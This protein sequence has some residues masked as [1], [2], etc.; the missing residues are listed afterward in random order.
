VMIE[1]KC[2]VCWKP[3]VY[4][5]QDLDKPQTLRCKATADVFVLPAKPP[6]GRL[7]LF[8]SSFDYCRD[9]MWRLITFPAKYTQ[10]E[11][12]MLL[13]A[14]FGI[15]LAYVLFPALLLCLLLLS[16]LVFLVLRI[17][18]G[19]GLLWRGI[20][21]RCPYDD[22]GR[23][24]LPIHICSCGNQYADL[25][26]DF[27]H[28]L[29]FHTCQHD[30]EQTRLPT[31]DFLGRK[32][33]PRLC[34]HC[35]RPVVLSSFGEL[36]ERPIAIVGAPSSGKT[37]FLRQAIRALHKRLGAIPGASVRVDSEPQ[38]RELERDLRL[39]DRGQV[40]AK[41]AGDVTQAFG[42]AL[43][44][45]RPRKFRCLLYLF[46]SPG[47]DFLTVARFGRKESVQHLKGIVLLIDPFSLP[48]LA[49][50]AKQQDGA[51]PHGEMGLEEVVGVLLAG[52]NQRL[53]NRPSEMS[54]VPVAVV[55]SKADTLPLAAFPILQG[56]CPADGRSDDERSSG[57]CRS[58]LI[59][60]GAGNTVRA[61]E[62]KFTRVRYFACTA[63]G[64]TP[65]AKDDRPF[66]ASGV[67]APLLWLLQLPLAGSVPAM[68]AASARR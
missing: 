55:L 62:H 54:S 56:L 47:E 58:A 21:C 37:L 38:A 26:P 17:A 29:F 4:E 19:T 1:V 53:V 64:R 39:L 36:P 22:C 3:H 48:A 14:P 52:V 33:L 18:H 24:G 32:K 12:V 49:D 59:Q 65:S 42:L 50:Y 66:Q 34:R 40:L 16:P 2:P 31:M 5:I 51:V 11:W 7:Y 23:A 25:R 13:W 6:P 60:L 45:P 15:A 30:N 43:R 63:L 61:L 68:A 35:K 57:R 9:L 67:A 46:D 27:A 44:I 28:G 8:N 10:R 41:T 20:F